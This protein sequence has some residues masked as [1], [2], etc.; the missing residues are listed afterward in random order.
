MICRTVGKKTK[1]EGCVIES[2]D[3]IGWRFPTRSGLRPPPPPPLRFIYL[4]NFSK[5]L[6][7]ADFCRKRKKTNSCTLLSFSQQFA[8]R[9][10]VLPTTHTPLP[11]DG[12]DD[13]SQNNFDNLITYHTKTA[14]PKLRESPW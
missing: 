13:L 8:H 3:N 9:I 7:N 6:C 1:K 10:V 5:L 4:Q 2:I 12:P 14:E 11:R